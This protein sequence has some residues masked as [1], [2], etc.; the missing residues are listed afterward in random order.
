M[1]R[2]G[3]SAL[4]RVFSLL[5]ADLPRNIL[6]ANP[7]NEAGHWESLDLLTIHDSL[8][9]TVGSRWDDWRTFNSDWMQSGVAESYREKLLDVLRG[10]F[11]DSTF[12]VIK[13]PRICRFVPLWLEVLDCF[14][15]EARVVVPVRNPL[16]VA[17]SH[18][19]RDGFPPAKSFLLWL[20]HVLDAEQA[21]RGVPRAV[22]AYNDLLDDW[23]SIV[24][25]VTAKTGLHWPRRSNRA[26][27]EIDRFLAEALRHHVANDAQLSACSDVV[28]WVKEAYRLLRDMAT[29]RETEDRFRRLDR[30]H[31]EFDKACATF[32]LV[33]AA[34]ADQS[35]A[36][37]QS[38]EARIKARDEKV[39]GLSA[40]LAQ[41]Q[42]AANQAQ[43]AVAAQAATLA[44]ELEAVRAEGQRRITEIGAQLAATKATVVE[45]NRQRDQL[46]VALEEEKAAADRNNSQAV[47]VAQELDAL[48]D[49]AGEYEAAATRLRAELDG[50]LSV[51][52]NRHS[53]LDKLSRKLTSVESALRDRDREIEGLSHDVEATRRSLRE[54]QTE[55]QR[56]G[57][58]FDG[59]RAEIACADGE[60]RRAFERLQEAEARLEGKSAEN[61]RL[62]SELARMR[63][64]VRR[65]E[66]SAAERV[67]AL[68]TSGVAALA[69]S[70]GNAQT[71]IRALRDQ[72]IDAEAGLAK[73]KRVSNGAAWLA[74][75]SK[76]RREARRLKNSGLFNADWYL[77]EY[78][79][80]VESGR[81]PTEHYLEDGYLRGYLP[82]PLFD[83]RWYL[84]CYEDVRRAGVNPAIHYLIYGG[85]EG[86]D[87][88]PL[89]DSDWYLRQNSD[90]RAAGMNPLVH[91]LRFGA[92]EGRDPSPLFDSQWYLEQ[93]PD[94]RAADVNPLLH[95]L[96][97]G[98]REGRDPHPL[99]DSSWYLEQNPDI[100]ASRKNPAAHYV[101]CGWRQGRD[102]HP[103]FDTSWYL[104][105]NPDITRARINPLAH[106]LEYGSNEGRWPNPNFDPNWYRQ[107]YA[108]LRG[109][110]IDSLVHYVCWGRSEGRQT[111]SP[112]PTITD[113]IATKEDMFDVGLSKFLQTVHSVCERN[114]PVDALFLLP[115]FGRGGAEKVALNFAR[116]LR[117]R[118]PNRSVVILVTD[119]KLL[120]PT[121]SVPDGMILLKLT[122]FFETESW[123]EK[124]SFTFKIIQLL[125][126]R[127]CHIINSDV[128]WNLV[129]K[130]GERLRNL[131][132]LYGSMFTFQKDFVTGDMIGYAANYYPGAIKFCNALLSDNKTFLIEAQKRFPA[133]IPNA[134]LAPVYN[135][136]SL[137]AEIISRTKNNLSKRPRVLWAGRLDRQK[138]I[139]VLF[140]TARKML[141]VDFFVYG[142]KVVNGGAEI[143]S[144]ENVFPEGPF[145]FPSELI[146]KREYDVYMYTTRED[147]LPNLLL[148]VGLMGIPIVAPAV[149]GIP[150]IIYEDTG[151]LLAPWPDA[152]EYAGAIRAVV[153]DPIRA[154]E[155]SCVLHSLI[156]QRHR[157]SAFSAT[158]EKIP[159]YL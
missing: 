112:N 107:H 148:E 45:L 63:A 146:A 83:T 47:L 74:P 149:G 59:V 40:E 35:A 12:F 52:N 121:I 73:A 33:L 157:W 67:A 5:G 61:E 43:V 10:D 130:K 19:R 57:G 15:A 51:A 68:E 87:P 88:N 32:G 114:G 20:R 111:Q 158:A 93:N 29:K 7:T 105:E 110:N 154:R 99:F 153:A 136:V 30:I 150:E 137:P 39:I 91:Y 138:R 159:G 126:P 24:R 152:A 144:L 81:S 1:H 62:A 49:T 26:E 125:R 71:Q 89:F 108:D 119:Y 80:V 79:D 8:L 60:R 69:E 64:E 22:I 139:E 97:F 151:Y 48:R 72:L 27:L 76:S 31:A 14:G 75:F 135:P 44:A 18:K 124:Q 77:R 21:T 11:A 103:D 122:D 113:G 96:N 56:L 86:R 133:D 85:S 95:Y 4:T 42:D 82:N 23:R 53:E 36:H 58:E 3:T 84:E 94:I 155:K 66:E 34:E 104:E 70:E 120:D 156:G 92:A 102:P 17:A 78:P 54:S 145:L 101:T 41:A 143:P 28:D 140:E 132:S 2:S 38:A 16:E 55:V 25:A 141:D 98:A 115:L 109:S 9:D 50:A 127:I 134:I 106:Y 116:L 13:D 118:K 46:V 123:T 100:L 90:V 37:L 117:E 131:T 147:G 142:S 65:I 129:M 6:G 128:G